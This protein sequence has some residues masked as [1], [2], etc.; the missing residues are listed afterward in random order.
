MRNFT[1]RFTETE[2]EREAFDRE[3]ERVWIPEKNRAA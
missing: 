3:R 1:H 2:R